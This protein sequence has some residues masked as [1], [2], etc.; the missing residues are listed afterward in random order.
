QP[1]PSATSSEPPG[2]ML[3]RLWNVPSLLGSVTERP[4]ILSVIRSH[5]L[6]SAPTKPGVLVASAIQGQG[7]IGKTVLAQMLAHDPVAREQFADGVYWLPFGQNPDILA[8]LAD[9]IRAFDTTYMVSSMRAA[10]GHLQGLL[11]DKNV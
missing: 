2:T 7:G 4:E 5:L 9:I 6:A 11:S 1:P 3:G 8:N 10:S